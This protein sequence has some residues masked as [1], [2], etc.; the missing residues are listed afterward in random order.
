M[1]DLS[2][3]NLTANQSGVGVTGQPYTPIWKLVLS[4]AGQSTQTYTK[5]RALSIGHIEEEFN[6]VA[7]VLLSNADNTL[8]TLDFERYKGVLSYGYNDPTNGDEYS[9]TAPLYV[10]GQRLYSAQGVLVCQLNLIG[11]PNMLGLDLAESELTLTDGDARTIKTLLT[12]IVDKTLAPYTNYTSYNATYD[13]TDDTLIGSFKPKEAFRVSINA[14]RLSM[15]KWLLAH[16][17]EKMIV[18]AD[19]KVHFLNPT[20]TGSTYAYEYKLAVS[21]EHTFFDKELRNRFV[22]PNK[23]VVSSHPSHTPQYTGNATSATSFALFPQTHTT[24]L[25]LASNTEASNIALA[26]IETNELDAEKGAVKVPMNVGQEIWD[27]IK[28]TDSRQNDSRTGNVRYIKRNVQIPQRGGNLVF[29]MDI[30]F[31]KTAILP[32]PILSP[33]QAVIIRQVTQSD[34]IEATAALIEAYQGLDADLRGL[35]AFINNQIDDAYFK[36]LTVT[37]ELTIPGEA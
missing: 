24:Y 8:T 33:T 23:E 20:T 26:K 1:R 16:T 7:T 29:D 27:W 25:R 18:K 4:R 10:T 15:L 14:S 31:G 17:G 34:V 30:R 9:A 19:G 6:G 37:D 32:T 12:A 28:V 21:G 11:T 13:G 35:I 5:T 3:T 22:N 36:R 2:A